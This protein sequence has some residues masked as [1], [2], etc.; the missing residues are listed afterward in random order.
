MNQE[1]KINEKAVTN[2]LSS[3]DLKMTIQ[4]HAQNAIHDAFSYGWNA[5]TLMEIFK[6][7]D[8]AYSIKEK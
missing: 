4:E 2:F 1:K 5:E 3:I 8:K 6:K 7:L